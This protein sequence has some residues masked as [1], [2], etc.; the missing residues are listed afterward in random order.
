MLSIIN[1][2]T[3]WYKEKQK[4]LEKV[5]LEILK[6]TPIGRYKIALRQQEAF[7][8]FNAIFKMANIISEMMNPGFSKASQEMILLNQ[9][10]ESINKL[11]ELNLNFK[12]KQVYPS[13]GYQAESQPNNPNQKEFIFNHKKQ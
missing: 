6:Q 10:F 11:I 5:R 9:A 13:G 12:R 3:N 8:K 4:A 2:Q 7:N 1:N